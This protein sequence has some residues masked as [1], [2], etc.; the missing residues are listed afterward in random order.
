M[1]LTREE[2]EHVALL[3]RLE[4]SD[5]EL[6]RLTE[7]LNAIL[8]HFQALQALDTRDIPPTSHVVALEN[9][10]RDDE[11]QPSLPPEEALRN[12]PDR[13]ADLF[14]VPRVVE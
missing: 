2:V 10:W 5:D 11:V 1:A 14:R 7:Q 3:A 9:V 6:A 12:A 8:G 13:I 4:L